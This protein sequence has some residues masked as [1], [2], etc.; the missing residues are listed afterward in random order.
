MDRDY[1]YYLLLSGESNYVINNFFI[2]S[3]VNILTF[4]FFY[5]FTPKIL[6]NYLPVS[7]WI[8]FQIYLGGL[9]F[10]IHNNFSPKFNTSIIIYIM[11]WL[12]LVCLTIFTSFLKISPKV[13]SSN[14][15]LSSL[16]KIESYFTSKRPTN[17]VLSA[18][19]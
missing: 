12:P 18:Y 16:H 14:N 8:F 7:I 5:K 1:G 4:L 6:A 11:T 2:L 9:F 10:C 3:I 15:Y 13:Q 17:S 19:V